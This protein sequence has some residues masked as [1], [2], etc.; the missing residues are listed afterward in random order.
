[1]NTPKI[2]CL[3]DWCNDPFDNGK[4]TMLVTVPYSVVKNALE[5]AREIIWM[6]MELCE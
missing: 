6:Y 1:M 4:G 2:D 5:E 3:E